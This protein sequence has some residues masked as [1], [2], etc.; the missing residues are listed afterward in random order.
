MTKVKGGASFRFLA[1][2]IIQNNLTGRSSEMSNEPESWFNA[3]L[4][5][6]ALI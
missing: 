6:L 2:E 4:I 1:F 5:M 3:L